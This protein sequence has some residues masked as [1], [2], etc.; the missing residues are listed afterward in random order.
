MA[1]A[2]NNSVAAL[3]TLAIVEEPASINSLPDELL[4]I[5]LRFRSEE[6]WSPQYMLE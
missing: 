4:S 5:I 2:D 3:A 1:E 6:P